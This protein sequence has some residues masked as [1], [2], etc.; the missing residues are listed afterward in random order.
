MRFE[1][2]G[3][4]SLPG[5]VQGQSVTRFRR[6][7]GKRNGPALPSHAVRD[8]VGLAGVLIDKFV[9][10]L[11]LYWQHQRLKANH[12]ERALRPIPMGRRN[13]LF[14]WAELGAKQVGIEVVGRNRT[15]A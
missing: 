6:V 14:C 11:P 12:L 5:A 8:V 13:W 10:H 15:V 7:A 3:V 9:Y 4:L 2:G 1:S